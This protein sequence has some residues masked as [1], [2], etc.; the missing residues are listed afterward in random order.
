MKTHTLSVGYALYLE[1][2]L[3]IDAETEEDAF[4][5]LKRM[6]RDGV[7]VRPTPGEM[8]QWTETDVM[9]SHFVIDHEEI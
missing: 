5:M 9:Q 4:A 2:Y 7:L 3:H 6:A 8:D 1:R